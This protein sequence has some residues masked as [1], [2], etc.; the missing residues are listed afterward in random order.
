MQNKAL[1]HENMIAF[2]ISVNLAVHILYAI[3]SHEL[4]EDFGWH[5]LPPKIDINL[6]PDR[7]KVRNLTEKLMFTWGYV[8][9]KYWGVNIICATFFCAISHLRDIS[10]ARHPICATFQ[11]R[12]ISIA[13]YPICATFQLRDIPSARQ[14]ICVTFFFTFWKPRWTSL[15]WP[16]MTKPNLT[17]ALSSL[18]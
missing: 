9:Q 14:P 8:V 7:N 12:D 1:H 3:I 17:Y 15:S 5:T 4:Y 16:N 10:I 2:V 18:A 6:A 13:R 11:M